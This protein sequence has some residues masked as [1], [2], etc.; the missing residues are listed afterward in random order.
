MHAPHFVPI[1]HATLRL[2]MNYIT[3]KNEKNMHPLLGVI[4]INVIEY[5]NTESWDEAMFTLSVNAGERWHAHST[6]AAL[7]REG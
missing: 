6:F 7:S 4:L 1:P 3:S 2:F 5:C